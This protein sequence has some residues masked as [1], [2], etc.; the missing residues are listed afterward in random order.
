MALLLLAGI[1]VLLAL[2]WYLGKKFGPNTVAGTG[3]VHTW[4]WSNLSR[5]AVLT[6][7]GLFVLVLFAATLWA[8]LR[9]EIPPANKDV[10]MVLVGQISGAFIT[11]VG[12]YFGSSKGSADMKKLMADVAKDGAGS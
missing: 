3:T 10:V 9:L 8:T 2:G 1:M 12:Y 5:E 7:V 4:D 11:V 6:I